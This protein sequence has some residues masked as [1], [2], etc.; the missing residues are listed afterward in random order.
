ML[1]EIQQK[2]IS[3][4]DEYE[5]FID[6]KLGLKATTEPLRKSA[7]INM[8]DCESAAQI[9]RIAKQNFGLRANYLIHNLNDNEV[10]SF[11]EINNIKLTYKC[12][13]KDDL[14]Q[15][16]GHNGN[17]YSI[18]K[19]Q[20]QIAY[21]EKNNFIFGERDVYKLNANDVENPALLS[22]FCI[23]I[24]NSKNNFQNELSVF[25]FD[26]GIKGNLLRKFDE[27]WEPNK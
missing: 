10:Y 6:G 27:N 23:C 5:I 7:K 26:I 2:T 18:F 1:I 19:N 8:F 3:L 9:V 22:A 20:K 12:I 14:Y 11:E 25:N 21:W 24:D 17:K 4:N 16:Y 15:L 13:Y